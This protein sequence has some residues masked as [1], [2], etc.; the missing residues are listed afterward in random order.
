MGLFGKKRASVESAVESAEFYQQQV[1]SILNEDGPYSGAWKRLVKSVEKS[2]DM[3]YLIE[4]RH[5]AED[6]S[7]EPGPW[8]QDPERLEHWVAD[9]VRRINARIRLLRSREPQ[10]EVIAGVTFYQPALR[11]VLERSGSFNQTTQLAKLIPE[12]N[13]PH[14]KNAVAVEIRG[15]RIGH[16]KREDAAKYSP[17]LQQIDKPL[18]RKV[19]VRKANEG[20]DEVLVALFY[21]PL[22]PPAEIGH[23]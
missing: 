4:L 19:T 6:V 13:N 7:T 12:P 2:N 15:Q 22:P 16:L 21:D 11:A 5:G 23:S 9:L 1:D 3:H 18:S 14:D 17:V 10:P 8:S 20:A